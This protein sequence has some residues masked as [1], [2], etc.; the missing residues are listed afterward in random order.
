MFLNPFLRFCLPAG[1]DVRLDG[2]RPMRPTTPFASDI[3]NY[4][5][6]QLVKGFYKFIFG[7]LAM[8]WQLPG[9]ELIWKMRVVKQ[10]SWIC[11]I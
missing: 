4:N 11:G 1:T 5:T 8:G 7:P 9:Q 3:L 6:K 10:E 2:A